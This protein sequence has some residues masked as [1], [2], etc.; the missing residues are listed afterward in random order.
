MLPPMSRGLPNLAACLEVCRELLADE[1][2]LLADLRAVF[3]GERP[4]WDRLPDDLRRG[5]ADIAWDA[6]VARGLAP[7]PDDRVFIDRVVRRCTG[8][9]LERPSW[10][11]CPACAGTGEEFVEKRGDRPASLPAALVLAGDLAGTLAAEA[12]AREA[13]TRLWP[14]RG[15]HGAMPR[16]TAS[17]RRVAWR[18]DE[19]KGQLQLMRGTRALCPLL[20]DVLARAAGDRR[21]PE[22]TAFYFA[23]RAPLRYLRSARWP[24]DPELER[25]ASAFYDALAAAGERVPR[26]GLT[27]GMPR[28]L[29][30]ER[31]APCDR[32]FAALPNP[33]APLLALWDLDTAIERLEADTIVLARGS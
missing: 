31:F 17:P 13:A 32:E 33:F 6:L 30:G 19:R 12:L 3:A 16:P 23:A 25:A 24:P 8:C 5:L 7:A 15:R 29:D 26:H 27:G 2:E 1:P 4:R 11:D 21:R 28:R 10:E 20:Y 14:W 18:V 22:S 9:E